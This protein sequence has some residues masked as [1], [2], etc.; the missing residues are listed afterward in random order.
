MTNGISNELVAML[1]LARRHPEELDRLRAS[2]VDDTAE[3]GSEAEAG[4]WLPCDRFNRTLSMGSLVL[5]PSGERGRLIRFDRKHERAVVEL[6]H[7][8]QRTLRLNKIEL[9][10][11]RPRKGTYARSA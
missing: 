4:P 2:I 11:G 8:G 10:R 6:D 7:G 9:R 3:P 5:T 1:E